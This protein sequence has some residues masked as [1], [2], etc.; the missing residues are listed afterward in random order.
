MGGIKVILSDELERKFREEVFRQMG[1][2]K[3][4]IKMAIDEAI[5][6]WIASRRKKTVSQPKISASLGNI[7]RA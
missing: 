3:G 1:M 5:N 6:E 2:K 7:V 4:N